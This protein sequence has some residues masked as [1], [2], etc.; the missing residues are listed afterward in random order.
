MKPDGKKILK[1][2]G[3][4]TISDEK[5]ESKVKGKVIKKP[6]KGPVKVVA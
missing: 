5:E 6:K 4:K 3:V 2:K 1:N